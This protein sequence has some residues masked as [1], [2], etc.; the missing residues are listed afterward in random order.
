MYE[1]FLKLLI[2]ISSCKFTVW[3]DPKKVD[4]RQGP[5]IFAYFAYL[6]IRCKF[7]GCEWQVGRHGC[8]VWHAVKPWARVRGAGPCAY[9]TG[10][11][12]AKQFRQP[13]D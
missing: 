5:K 6:H 8:L 11:V 3:S 13:P 2:N 9:M 7:D 12:P 10:M 4:P 1:H